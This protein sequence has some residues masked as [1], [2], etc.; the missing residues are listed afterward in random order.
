MSYVIDSKDNRHTHA[1][2]ERECANTTRNIFWQGLYGC[3]WMLRH[4]AT[5]KTF[6][7]LDNGNRHGHLLP[8]PMLSM[9]VGTS[10]KTFR[11]C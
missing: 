3:D 2:K 5:G 4:N 6:V 7:L 11:S 1:S 9:H 10:C 8:S